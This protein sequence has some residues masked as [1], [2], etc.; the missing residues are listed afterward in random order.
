VKDRATLPF[1]TYVIPLEIHGFL[2]FCLI[3][4]STNY[5]QQQ[6]KREEGTPKGEKERN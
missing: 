2:F 6:K 3:H 4:D 1:S 5:G